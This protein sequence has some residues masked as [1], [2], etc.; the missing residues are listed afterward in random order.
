[1]SR[2]TM[3]Q[4]A[5]LRWLER[6]AGMDIGRLQL[7]IEASLAKAHAAAESI[8]GGNYLIVS[9]G[10][11]YAVRDGVVVTVLDQDSANLPRAVRAT[12]ER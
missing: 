11:V 2:I 6:A 5:M 9:G 3:S 12:S 10:L 4:H 7:Q 1:M 8:G